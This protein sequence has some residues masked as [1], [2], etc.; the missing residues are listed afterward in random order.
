MLVFVGSSAFEG[1]AVFFLCYAL[2][3]CAMASKHAGHVYLHMFSELSH[4]S[5]HTLQFGHLHKTNH[6]RAHEQEDCGAL[7]VGLL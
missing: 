5:H 2:E 3:A 1:F 7:M 6:V 4:T